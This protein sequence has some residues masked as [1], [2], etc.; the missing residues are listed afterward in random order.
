MRYPRFRAS[1]RSQRFIGSHRART[2]SRVR[3]LLVVLCGLAIPAL[4]SAQINNAASA[5]GAGDEL[6]DCRLTFRVRQ[7]LRQ[8]P[9]LAGQSSLGVSVRSGVANLW[10]SVPTAELRLR[11]ERLALQVQGI[12]SVRNELRVPAPNDPLVEFLHT[13][14]PRRTERLLVLANHPPA[15]LTGRAEEVPTSPPAAAPANG[16]ALL[17]PIALETDTPADLPAAVARLQQADPRFRAVQ[18][19]IDNGEVRLNGLVQR[20]EDIFELAKQIARLPGVERVIL[21]EVHTPLDRVSR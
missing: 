7:A 15:T 21:V 19:S 10:G 9:D 6:H 2:V 20:W 4:P 13:A 1:N 18:A 14:P 5:S 3:L 8:D 17:P 16:V 11:A 12:N